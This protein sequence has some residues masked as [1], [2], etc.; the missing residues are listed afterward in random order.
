MGMTVIESSPESIDSKG[1]AFIIPLM[2]SGSVF[3]GYWGYVK[4]GIWQVT[5]ELGLLNESI[6]IEINTSSVIK[7]IDRESKKV[8]LND[9]KSFDY[10][11]LIFATG[12]EVWV[13][14]DVKKQLPDLNIKVVNLG[15]WKLFEEQDEK[16]KQDVLS[17]NDAALLV[18][19]EAGITSGWQKYT[20]RNGLNIGIDTFGESAPGNDVAD[21]F[22]LTPDKVKKTIMNKL[23]EIK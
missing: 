12:S 1:S 16:Y 18:S 23:E 19:L 17:C 5:E 14:L 3:D 8:M 20:G 22:G 7:S 6:G 9:G 2:D 10:D 11:I 21:H 4:H 15:C 13:A